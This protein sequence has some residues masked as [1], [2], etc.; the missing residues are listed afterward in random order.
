MNKTLG[1]LGL[2]AGLATLGSAQI[3]KQGNG[4]LMRMKFVKG[5]NMSYS[6]VVKGGSAGQQ[7]NMTSPMKMTVASTKGTTGVLNYAVG[8]MKMLMNGKPLNIGGGQVTKATVTLDNRG[9]VVS[10]AA[11]SNPGGTITLPAGPIAV[12]GTWTGS[13][14][15]AAGA[16]PMTVNAT[17]KL[18]GIQNVGG[19][20]AAKISI[21][22]K[23][24][25]AT[26]V[27]GTGIMFLSVADGSLIRNENNM[28]VSSPQMPKP[29]AMTMVIARK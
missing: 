26:N 6:M 23:G 28:T 17:Y 8:P 13:T 16:A 7:F 9:K 24:T 29:M 27:S 3:T 21:S 12:G 10:G 14:S 19:K 22:M 15:V 20:S 2:I 11:G 18:L 4:Y 5:A 1:I 25:G